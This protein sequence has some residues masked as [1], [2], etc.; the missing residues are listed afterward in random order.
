MRLVYLGS[1]EFGVP[2]LEAMVDSDHELCMIVTQPPHPCGRGRKLR[3]TAAARWAESRG[4]PCVGCENV[5][6]P[7]MVEQLAACRPD[8]MVVIACGQK[9]GPTLVAMPP[10][11]AINVHASLL[12]KF[13]GAAPINWA[14]VRGETHTGISIIT[15][16]DKIDAGD[17]L[18]QAETLIGTHETAGELHDRLAQLSAPLLMETLSQLETGTATYTAQDR[19]LATFAPKLQKS[20]GFLDFAKPAQA[21]ARITRG[22][23]PWPGASACHISAKTGKSTHVVIALADVIWAS[24]AKDQAPGEFD[25]DLNV[26]CG[27][28][29][30]GIMRIKPAGSGLMDFKDFI[31][32]WRVSPGDRF[33]KVAP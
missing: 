5:N 10:K 22:F 13:R 11:G 16:A 4:V 12:P 17:V 32:G 27:E 33:V 26:V 29:K 18:G 6:S 2:C 3:A 28:G 7:E 24:G 31:N 23:W 19:A 9:I 14:I 21:L 25:E 30:L 20:D 1:G 15:L 8:V